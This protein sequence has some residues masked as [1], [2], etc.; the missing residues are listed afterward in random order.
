MYV[1]CIPDP[2]SYQP[3]EHAPPPMIPVPGGMFAYA[4]P[5]YMVPVHQPPFLRPPE[6]S[7]PHYVTNVVYQTPSVGPTFAP[8]P[9]PVYVEEAIEWIAATTF[10]VS[11]LAQKAFVGGEDRSDGSPLYVIRAQHEGGLV[12]GKLSIKNL[13]AY[14]AYRGRSVPVDSFEVLC[15]KR[16]AVSW[17]SSSKGQ[18]PSDA[19]IAGNTVNGEPLF[20]ARVRHKGSLIPGKVHPSHGCCYIPIGR[21]ETNHKGY[22]VLC[23]NQ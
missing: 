8:P 18:V 6:P 4:P 23:K 16:E 10:D 7:Q 20:I 13:A 3:H 2:P 1:L 17:K 15:A 14:I 11:R 12:P 21:Y 22:E 19:I 5:P 9:G